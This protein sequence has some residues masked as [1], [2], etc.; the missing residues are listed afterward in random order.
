MAALLQRKGKNGVC[1]TEVPVITTKQVKT[2]PNVDK[3][4]E[5]IWDANRIMLIFFLE[6][7]D[8]IST[9]CLSGGAKMAQDFSLQSGLVSQRMLL[10]KDDARL[11]TVAYTTALLNEWGYKYDPILQLQSCPCPPY[12]HLLGKLKKHL[13]KQW[14]FFFLCCC[15]QIFQL[16]SGFMSR[17][18]L[19]TT[20]ISITSFYSMAISEPVW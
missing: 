13:Q 2:Y 5:N 20:R 14:F 19:L 11:H 4:I 7:G 8:I 9:H 1:N 12:Y 16:N 10:F 18:L 3:L 15:S 17:L 6:W